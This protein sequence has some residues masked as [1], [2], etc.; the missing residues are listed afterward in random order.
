MNNIKSYY[1]GEVSLV[2]LDEDIFD[3][4]EIDEKDVGDIVNIPRSVENTQ[5]AVSI[6]KVPQ[7]VKIS[8][9]SNGK[10]N[11]GE[12]AKT[13]D[14]GGHQM[15]AGVVLFDATISEAEDKILKVIGE[16]ING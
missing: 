9:R 7:K 10:Y 8:L 14:G 2:A 11:V 1:N 5:I 6:R 3:K 4:Y 13:L 16:Y 15:A 12:I